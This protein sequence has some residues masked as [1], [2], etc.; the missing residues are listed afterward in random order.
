MLFARSVNM[1]IWKKTRRL[2]RVKALEVCL[3]FAAARAPNI[4]RL[5]DYESSDRRISNIFIVSVIA[6]ERKYVNLKENS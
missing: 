2:C 1:K 4:Y 5:Y 6:N 3:I